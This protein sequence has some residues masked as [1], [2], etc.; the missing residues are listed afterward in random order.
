MKRPIIP[1]IV[2]VILLYV[3]A[4]KVYQHGVHVGGIKKEAEFFNKDIRPIIREIIQTEY[5]NYSG[6]IDTTENLGY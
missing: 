4:T 2:L 6:P 5:D 1:V 3:I